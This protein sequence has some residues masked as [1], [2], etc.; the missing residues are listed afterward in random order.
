M[1]TVADGRIDAL[2]VG[3]YVLTIDGGSAGGRLAVTCDD[4]IDNNGYVTTCECER[5]NRGNGRCLRVDIEWTVE[6]SGGITLRPTIVNIEASNTNNLGA[7][8]VDSQFLPDIPSV[9][10]SSH[11]VL[12]YQ[13]WYS[14]RTLPLLKTWS[15][16]ETHHEMS[17]EVFIPVLEN[18]KLHLGSLTTR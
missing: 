2:S 8:P 12:R 16:L 18:G 11:R 10:A 1:R 15:A 3:Q 13:P 17:S 9:R 14:S 5:Q 7:F 6:E 4:I